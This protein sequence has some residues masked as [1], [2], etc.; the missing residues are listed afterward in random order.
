MDLAKLVVVLEAQSAQY[1]AQF[2]KAEKRL[3]SLEKT[4]TRVLGKIDAGFRKFSGAIAGGL[5]AIGVGFS[6]SAIVKAT[7]EAEEAMAL[8][9]N[10]VKATGGSAGY[11]TQ[12]L[13]DMAGQLQKVSKFDDEAIMGAQ[14]LLLRFQ[15]IQGLRFD[16]AQKA[17]LDVATA[18]RMDLSSAAILVGKSLE[19]PVKGMN[20]LAR[21][22]IVLSDS[23]KAMIK[24]LVEAGDKAKAQEIILSA[25]E[26]RYGG[27]ALAARNTFGGALA[28]LKNAFNDLLEGKGGMQ[29]ATTAINQLT[30][31]LNSEE[32]KRGF[33]I[34]I[35]GF[36]TLIEWAAKAAAAVAGFAKDIGEFFGEIAVG[37]AGMTTEQLGKRIEELQKLRQQSIDAR[38]SNLDATS[39]EQSAA[40]E[41][42]KELV[43]GYDEQ[44][45][46]LTA[47]KRLHDGLGTAAK[48]D[49]L[50]EVVVTASKI[51]MPKSAGGKGLGIPD[52][53]VTA[54]KS[55]SDSL[56]K[57]YQQWNH[58]TQTE[59]EKQVAQWEEFISK[60]TELQKIPIEQGGITAEEA[61]RR[62]KEFNDETLKEVDVTAK[63]LGDTL[64]KKFD[65]VSEFMKQASRNVQDILGTAIEDAM[66]GKFD[67]ILSS[68]KHMLDQMVAQ[69][70]A[71][72]LAQKLFGVG[73]VG[74]G[75]G[76]IGK[77]LDWLGGL[78]GGSR[79]SGGRGQ[80]GMAYA[81]GASAKPE[82]FVPDSSGTFY[83]RDQW[84]GKGGGKV[85]QNI[86]VQGRMDQRTA[87]QLDLDAS[88]RQRQATTRLS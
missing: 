68:F 13:A 19:D 5:A 85:T 25:L 39:L 30:D 49:D 38:G 7:E 55:G 18:L 12:Q 35:T 58:D 32:V 27:A 43:R 23:Q 16:R 66:G 67:N 4:Q 42:S 41:T 37:P 52:V 75:G 72:Q 10:A 56:M 86:Y 63:K 26:Q 45:K 22:G 24:T 80:P 17:V 48:K 21:S 70:L 46:K 57:L 47:L 2:D 6:F 20:Q 78:F 77:G 50:N 54:Q 59:I 36:A 73:G 76:W 9:D 79:D 81:I 65:Q 33:E 83:P 51:G 31:V 84:M 3:D 1:M 82:L 40:L 69:A 61:T 60:I 87:R 8:L 53:M 28:G 44:I 71:A 88:R 14:Q 34:I 29:D 15:S 64:T 62:I 74:G 11:T